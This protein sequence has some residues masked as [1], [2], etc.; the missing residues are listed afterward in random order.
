MVTHDER[1]RVPA[2][3]AGPAVAAVLVFGGLLHGGFG[4]LRALLSYGGVALVLAVGLAAAST[5]RVRVAD[6]VL[7]AG[8]ARLPLDVVGAVHP[9]DRAQTRRALG[10]EGDPTAYV[11]FRAWLP[12]SVLV[13]LDD[14]A[15]PTPY[16]LV[17]TRRP[18][19]LARALE[20]GR[21]EA[22]RRR[23]GGTASA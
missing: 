6:G 18:H 13:E 16:W 11:V 22:G 9:L 23:A 15:D 1:L 20:Q 19:A 2:W 3:W 21:R 5:T 12:G 4:P 17:S 8:R 14:P 7:E 10:P